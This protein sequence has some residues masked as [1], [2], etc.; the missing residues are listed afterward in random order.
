MLEMNLLAIFYK[1]IFSQFLKISQLAVS[2][3]SICLKYLKS[4]YSK[5]F[6]INPLAVF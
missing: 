4:I 1:S 5:Y 3:K 2:W 6:E